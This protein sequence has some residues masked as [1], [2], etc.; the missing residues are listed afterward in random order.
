[1]YRKGKGNVTIVY[2]DHI[3]S[4]IIA[5]SFLNE[6]AIIYRARIVGPRKGKKEIYATWTPSSGSL[7]FARCLFYCLFIVYLFISHA[8]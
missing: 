7:A 6:Y 1:M 3:S 8:C 5:L 4:C 2:Y